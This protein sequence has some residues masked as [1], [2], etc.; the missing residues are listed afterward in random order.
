MIKIAGVEESSVPMV[1]RR[2]WQQPKMRFLDMGGLAEH[3]N[4]LKTMGKT[5]LCLASFLRKCSAM[6]VSQPTSLMVSA[7]SFM[8]SSYN[9]PSPLGSSFKM[10]GP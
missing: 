1:R 8:P 9:M 3:T 7:I 5:W 10:L 6:V 2:V 4:K